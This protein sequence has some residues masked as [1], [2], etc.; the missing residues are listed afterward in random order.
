MNVIGLSS[1]SW[2]LGF[3]VF[4]YFEE[5]FSMDILVVGSGGREHALVWKL[6]QSMRVRNIYCAPGNPGIGQIAQCVNIKADNVAELVDFV[7][8]QNIDLTIV[9]PEVS[10]SAG[11]VDAL[12]AKGYKAFG[13]TQAAA[14]IEGSKAFAKH[15]MKK[16]HIP[17]GDYEVFTELEAALSYIEEKGAP[18]VVKADGLAAGK[19]V[20]VAM[21][22]ETAI[23]AVK[24]IMGDKIFG[25]AGHQVVL[26]EYLEGEEASLL[27]FSDGVRVAPMIAAQD[28]KRVFDHDEGPNT[29]GMGTY[30]PAPV[31]TEEIRQQVV[32]EVLLPA[33]T[34]MA[35]EGRPY[36]GVLYA[37]LMITTE[38]PKVIEFNARF[39]D[40][41][42]QV[43]LPLLETDLV[44]ICE[45]VID[46]R[47]DRQ[48]ITWDAGAAVC[49]VMASGG[50]PGDFE[51]GKEI[52][53][54]G[55][56]DGMPGVIT[57][58]AGTGKTDGKLVTAGGR[59]LGV[60]ARGDS[61]ATAI[62]RAY[63]GVSKIQFSG[64][65]YRKDIGQRAL[66]RKG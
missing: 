42:T 25:A 30:A 62:E 35:A 21:D 20:I 9:G 18:I 5:V 41:E 24:S 13:P 16:Y 50:Y 63:Q 54:L 55:D 51:K 43:I 23:K 56:A 3:F 46:G 8:A 65:H 15:L 19:G 7:A 4:N 28:H 39:G 58:H 36:K 33:V 22:K 10:L 59:V 44:D 37:G 66:Q 40:P 1:F 61:I 45:A 48:V 57:F 52:S 60:T 64:M 27:A 53:G 31:V 26:E 49:V 14:E 32:K 6:A 38:G 17:T 29:G 11:L 34:A 2:L 12:Q 47:L